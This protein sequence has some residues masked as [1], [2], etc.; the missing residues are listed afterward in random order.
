[1]FSS[2]LD[3][4]ITHSEISYFCLYIKTTPQ[5]SL[6]YP[7]SINPNIYS[8]NKEKQKPFKN[9]KKT[10]KLKKISQIYI[11]YR[12]FI[13]RS[14]PTHTKTIKKQEKVEKMSKKGPIYSA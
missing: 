1:M 10:L 11:N 5:K 13:K 3:F 6:T 7:R 9:T 4:Y 8:K 2:D 12:I 14:A